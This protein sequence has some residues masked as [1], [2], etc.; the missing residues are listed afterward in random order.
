MQLLCYL[1]MRAVIYF[2]HNN[3]ANCCRLVST[4]LARF[5]H[6]R[7][8]GSPF[9]L[10]KERR[11]PIQAVIDTGVV[12]RLTEFLEKSD[13]PQLQF[14]AAWVLTNIAV[15]TSDQTRC[16]IDAGA[17][18]I[19]VRLLQSPDRN[20]HEQAAWALGNIA[21]DSVACR[22]VVLHHGAIPA[23]A[24]IGSVSIASPFF[25]FLCLNESIHDYLQ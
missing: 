6:F 18:P 10:F 19:F 5:M 24:Q 14:E 12:P 13:N 22:D 16:V 4:N 9:S 3:C 2:P 20:V 23:L 25:M 11:P 1:T 21:G 8:H 7:F 17:L 15:G